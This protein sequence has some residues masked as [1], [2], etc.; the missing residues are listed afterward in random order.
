MALGSRDS[1]GS[2]RA[3][4]GCQATITV[5]CPWR[6][7]ASLQRRMT[8]RDATALDRRGWHWG[9]RPGDPACNSI[10][11][12]PSRHSPWH[13]DTQGFKSIYRSGLNARIQTYIRARQNTLCTLIRTRRT[14]VHLSIGLYLLSCWNANRQPL[15]RIAYRDVFWH[16]TRNS[17]SSP[18]AVAIFRITVPH[19][20]CYVGEIEKEGADTAGAT[21]VRESPCR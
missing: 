11:L 2:S 12:P 21:G 8:S 16:A 6:L 14:T 3:K 5:G 7:V 20:Y 1:N 18:L 4:R 15:I 9:E 10:A 19:G 13:W 17:V